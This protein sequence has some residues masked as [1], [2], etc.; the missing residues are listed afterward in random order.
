[1]R[2]ALFS[3]LHGSYWTL[4]SLIS[5]HFLPSA[6]NSVTV[7]FE[8]ECCLEGFTADGTAITT[9]VACDRPTCVTG[10]KDGSGYGNHEQRPYTITFSGVTDPNG[11]KIAV[12]LKS[13]KCADCVVYLDGPSCIAGEPDITDSTDPESTPQPSEE[14]S[15]D[16]SSKPSPAPTA[17]HSASPS[18]A[19]SGSPSSEHSSS[20]SVLHSASPTDVVEPDSVCGIDVKFEGCTEVCVDGNGVT[21][22]CP[23]VCDNGSGGFTPCECSDRCNDITFRLL[24]DVVGGLYVDPGCDDGTT[25]T[26]H[27]TNKDD[28]INIACS[29]FDSK[30]YFY[31]NA[32]RS[33][34]IEVLHA[35]CSVPIIVGQPAPLD[36]ETPGSPDKGDP[37][38]LLFVEGFIEESGRV[39]DPYVAPDGPGVCPG[40]LPDSEPTMAPTKAP[41]STKRGRSLLDTTRGRKRL[42]IR[43]SKQSKRALKGD[44][45]PV[46]DVTMTYQCQY[47]VTNTGG[48]IVTATV[49]G[50]STDLGTLPP[51]D[52][53]TF[54]L[55]YNGTAGVCPDVTVNASGEACTASASWSNDT[56]AGTDNIFFEPHKTLCDGLFCDHA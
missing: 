40:P 42:G 11:G 35:S 10:V 9:D 19:H 32:D 18:I 13:G 17:Q 33:E 20:P 55:D 6:L 37:S 4:S 30:M 12:V 1:M 39:V 24:E 7:A 43:G 23:E 28:T 41:K 47:N 50:T 52:S 14:P 49:D 25:F 8:D 21:T 27:T 56:E 51:S 46:V 26:F 29:G 36:S 3:A 44:K 48:A 38:K 31:N 54:L 22:S 45:E 34:L 15:S 5:Y 53:A 2:S 16:P